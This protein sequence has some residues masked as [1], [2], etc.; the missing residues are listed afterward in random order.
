MFWVKNLFLHIS[1]IKF[2]GGIKLKKLKKLVSLILGLSMMFTVLPKA[3]A[4]VE[5]WTFDDGTRVSKF[6]YTD[7]DYM[8]K[9][10]EELVQ[11][12]EKRLFTKRQNLAVKTAG[13]GLGVG[14]LAGS[15][16]LTNGCASSSTLKNIAAGVLGFS[17]LCSIAASFYPEF[18]AH[19]VEKTNTS[20]IAKKDLNNM[21]LLG[22]ED[23]GLK[24]ICD[25]LKITKQ[26]LEELKSKGSKDEI[27]YED[28]KKYPHFILV[29]RPE[30]VDR[31]TDVNVDV[32]KSTF[33]PEHLFRTDFNLKLREIFANLK[34]GE[35]L[36]VL[37][38]DKIVRLD[39]NQGRICNNEKDK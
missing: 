30:S 25:F 1:K 16:A 34:G 3:S 33:F 37:A 38:K 21:Y 36:K 11:E 31:V 13:I 7:F 29:D 22:L 19:D 10:Y 35:K 17:G 14:L 27:S 23:M 18:V 26:N 32:W 39:S 24:D 28:L 4:E 20:G 6:K 9:F 15:M 8:I 12:N 5:I 2:L